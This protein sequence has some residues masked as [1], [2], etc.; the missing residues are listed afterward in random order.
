MTATVIVPSQMPGYSHPDFA[1]LRDLVE[2]CAANPQPRDA[3]GSVL[4]VESVY[5]ERI[6]TAD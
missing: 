3:P 6:L 2:F 5:Q 4:M 1:R